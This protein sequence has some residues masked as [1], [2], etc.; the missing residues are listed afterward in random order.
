MKKLFEKHTIREILRKSEILLKEGGFCT[1]INY[2]L[3]G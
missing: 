1:L 3:F 2:I